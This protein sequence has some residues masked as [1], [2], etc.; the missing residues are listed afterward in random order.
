MGAF[1][2]WGAD[3]DFVVVR[4][5]HKRTAIAKKPSAIPYADAAAAS[6]AGLIALAGLT[7]HGRLTAKGR[8]LIIGASGG[9]GHLATQIA[10]RGIGAARVIGVCSSNNETFVRGCGAHEVIAYDR[11][12]IESIADARPDLRGTFD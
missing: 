9:V 1:R 8:V 6:F 7:T 2:L 11:T 3:A 5:K 10:R 12:P 4:P